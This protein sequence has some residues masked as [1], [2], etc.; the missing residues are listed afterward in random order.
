MKKHLTRILRRV[1]KWTGIELPILLIVGLAA[2]AVSAFVQI[3]DEVL[4]GETKAFDETI[5]TWLRNPGDM[6]D[7]V[8][9][10]WLQTIFTDLTALGGATSLIL[11]TLA[12]IGYLWIEGK[13]GRA[14]LVLVSVAGGQLFSSL[15]KTAFA[16]PRPELVAHLVDVHTLSFPSG[17]AMLSAVT[18]LTLG[19]LLAQ[20][21]PQRRTKIYLMTVACVLTLLIGL[22]RIYLG[23]HYPTDVLAG[24][25]AGAAWAAGCWGVAL[26]FQRRGMIK[27]E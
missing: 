25:C 2:G 1:E 5:L 6:A 9:P 12:A 21:R 20:S 23:V 14:L 22:S 13:R 16:R 8:G 11:I 17:H 15:L 19:V 24:W 18:F 26:W 10:W 27:N 3:A 7:P 4:E